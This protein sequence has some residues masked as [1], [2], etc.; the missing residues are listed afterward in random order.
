MDNSRLKYLLSRYA[1]N[2]ATPAEQEELQQFLKTDDHDAQLELMIEEA[3]IQSAEAE[4]IVF[5]GQ[6]AGMLA[7]ILPSAAE[8]KQPAKVFSWQRWAAAVLILIGTG[9]AALLIYQQKKAAQPI[10]GKTQKQKEV[11]PGTNKAILTL[12]DGATIA[13]DSN[14]QGQVAQQ[15]NVNLQAAAG[16][17]IYKAG[18]TPAAQTITWNTLSTPK[19][20]QYSLVLPDGSKVWLNAASSLKYPTAFIGNKRQVT[21]TGEAYFEIA[22]NSE[23]PFFVNAGETEVAVL[24]TSFN[25]MAY[26]NENNIKTTLLQGTVKV[27]KQT[28]SRLLKPGQQSLVSENGN[29]QVV[30][31]A[32]TDLAVAWKNG[33]TSF[34][35]AD[36]QT[37][38]RQVER[39]Y[40]IDVV[41]QGDI[42]TRKFTGDI[43]RSADLSALLHLLEISRIRYKMEDD[44]LIVTQ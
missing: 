35:S 27:S 38:M 1:D 25:V 42:P 43:P 23:Q 2:A 44:H 31:N 9:V 15:G 17:L 10:T 4:G 28:E 30:D 33:L 13:L 8:K 34:K 14:M 20:G 7:R 12:A 32:D 24:G 21:L 39:W 11:L 37:I 29:M 19:G 36:I 5:T 3:W 26:A 22:K 18:T 16:K 41:F 40:N 6:S